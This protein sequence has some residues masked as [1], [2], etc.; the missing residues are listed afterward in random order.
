MTET[1]ER[2]QSIDFSNPY[3]ETGL[4]LLVGKS[5]GIKSIQDAD[6]PNC[7]IAVK[8]GTTG[9]AYARNDLKN[10]QIRVLDKEDACVLE[11][12]QGKANAF[13]YDQMSVYKHWQLHTDQ[14]TAIL[15]PFRKESWAIGIR[16]GQSNLREEVNAFLKKYR[17]DGG[18]DRL[19]NKY[20]KEQKEAFQ[21][22]GISFYF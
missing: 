10:A 9:Q 21:K 8:Q 16:K 2:K 4:C 12:V 3:L 1:E 14:T 19:G 15:Q 6:R 18:F 22:L 20:L 5:S 7:I 11:V 13:I 17:A